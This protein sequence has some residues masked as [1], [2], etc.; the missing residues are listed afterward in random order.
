MRLCMETGTF[1]RLPMERAL[2]EIRRAGYRYVE[3]N[4]DLFKPHEA[5]RTDIKRLKALLREKGLRPAAVLPLY[6]LANPD[7]NAR[8]D[9]VGKW[10][11]AILASKELGAEKLTSEMT[12]DPKEPVRSR[13]AFKRSMDALVPVLEEAGLTACFEPH[14]GDF[15][16]SSNEA[17]D[18][19]REIG[20]PHVAYL[21]CMPH[22]FYLG[23]DIRKMIIYAGATLGHVHVGDSLRPDRIIQA[24]SGGRPHNHLIPGLGEVDFEAAFAAL[25]SIGYEGYL[26]AALFSH[27]D[28]PTNAARQTREKVAEMLSELG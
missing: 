13:D 18:L 8:L 12:G 21:Y 10:K 23:D 3:L 6:S 1:Q 22:T 16:E 9:A 5:T 11:R 24:G 15:I 7:E 17:V 28:E 26:S 14:P 19:I 27:L 4:P 2:A 20:S 25:R